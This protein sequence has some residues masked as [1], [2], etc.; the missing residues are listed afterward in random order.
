MIYTR[1]GHREISP[2][3]VST[4]SALPAGIQNSVPTF[5]IRI[6]RCRRTFTIHESLFA[7]FRL[8]AYNAFNHINAGNPSGNASTVN[9]D[10]GEVFIT[11]EPPGAK[12]RQLQLS[13]RFQF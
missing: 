4:K 3:L 6:W 10:Q 7:Q 1:T 13:V 12:P 11:S 5:S 2:L 9:I 8:D